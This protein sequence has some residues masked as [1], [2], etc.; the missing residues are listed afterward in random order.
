MQTAQGR[1]AAMVRVPAFVAIALMLAAPA[2]AQFGGLKKKVKEAT[3]TQAASPAATE[4][5]ATGPAPVDATGGTVVLT[6]QVVAQLIEGMNA[7]AAEREAAKTGDTP[8]GRYNKESA[9]YEA[10]KYAGLQ[11]GAHHRWL[12]LALKVRMSALPSYWTPS[13]A[14][15][16]RGSTGRTPRR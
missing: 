6:D 7:A 9:A 10:A 12:P 13:G 5:G 11:L 2:S 8:Y 15:A 3:S 14:A 16:G 1:L 4:A